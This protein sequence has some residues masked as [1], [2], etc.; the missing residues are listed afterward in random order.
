MSQAQWEGEAIG[1]IL[2][3]LISLAISGAE[4]FQSW[5][6]QRKA[7]QPAPCVID[8]RAVCGG[9]KVNG[10]EEVTLYLSDVQ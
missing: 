1:S 5:N 4:S 9:F 3:G 10:E 7:V 6:E 8:T 2:G